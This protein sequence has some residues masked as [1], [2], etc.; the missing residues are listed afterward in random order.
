MKIGS[1][2]QN[3]DL[4]DILS[5]VLPHE[6]TVLFPLVSTNCTNTRILL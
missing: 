3:G 5:D 1:H 6:S 4:S 2:E